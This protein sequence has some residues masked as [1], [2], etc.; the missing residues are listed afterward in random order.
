MFCKQEYSYQTDF[1][2]PFNGSSLIVQKNSSPK[3]KYILGLAVD[4]E[5]PSD[6]EQDYY[7]DTSDSDSEDEDEENEDTMLDLFFGLRRL[8]RRRFIQIDNSVFRLHWQLTSIILIAFS[9]AIT[10]RQYVGQ[11]IDCLQTDEI[12]ASVLNT[13]CWIH[14]TFTIPSAFTMKVGTEV[15]HPGIDNSKGNEK[16]HYAYYQWVCFALFLQGIFFYLPY[17]LWKIWEGGLMRAISMGMQIAII[18]DE[19]KGH[20][21]RVL[22]DYL[23]HHLGQHRIYALKYFICEILCLVNVILQMYF[24]DWFFDGEFLTYGLDVI[25]NSQKDQEDRIDPMVFVFPRM[26]KCTF[27]SYGSSGDVQ[28]HDA[29]CMLP[30]NVVNEKIYVF[31]WFWFYFLGV[32]TSIVILYRLFIVVAVG[33]RARFLHTRCRLSTSK[34]LDQICRKGNIGDWFVLY[35]LGSN[36]DPIVTRELTSDL[37]HRLNMDTSKANGVT[38]ERIHLV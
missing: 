36:L 33:W 4:S 1:G 6:D 27:H 2:S 11:N 13:Y 29:L 12:P 32:I 23:Y 19:E 18:S 15:P 26:T 16:K 10:A 22:I 37:A 7:Y 28:R 21:K 30:L 35:M 3:E 31:L 9:L 24:M 5:V 17:Y 14:S 25:R 34:D 20:K 38:D 8:I